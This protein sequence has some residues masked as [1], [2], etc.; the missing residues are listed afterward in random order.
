MP[1]EP[2]QGSAIH[3]RDRLK[4]ALRRSLPGVLVNLIQTLRGAWGDRRLGIRTQSWHR[5]DKDDLARMAIPDGADYQPT[6]Y[7]FLRKL[8][9]SLPL[10]PE[11]TFMDLGCGKGRVVCYLAA[12]RRLRKAIGVDIL[13]GLT[14][15]AQANAQRIRSGTPIEI[16]TGDATATDLSE[17]TVLFLFNPFGEGT[18]AAVLENLRQSLE[19]NPRYCRIIYNN[20]QCLECLARCPWLRPLEAVDYRA[21]IWETAPGGFTPPRWRAH[22]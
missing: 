13:P 15:I 19:A 18:L 16:R 11:D 21:T 2:G 17:V 5:L 3:A 20:P 8:L 22:P 12:H 4:R 9:A 6:S 1:P 10:E 7:H 14:R